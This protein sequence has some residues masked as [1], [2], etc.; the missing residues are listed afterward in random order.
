MVAL[1][2]RCVQAQT[3]WWKYA[4]VT[5]DFTTSNSHGLSSKHH[6]WQTWS[7]AGRTYHNSS[8]PGAQQKSCVHTFTHRRA[9]LPMLELCD[10]SQ[11]NILKRQKLPSFKHPVIGF[12]CHSVCNHNTSLEVQGCAWLVL[13]RCFLLTNMDFNL[14]S[15]IL[16]PRK[17]PSIFM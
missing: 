4:R 7:W 6:I 9:R 11:L 5:S 8:A 15:V 13:V 3:N 16:S 12:W 2:I 1:V 14:F 10:P 17:T